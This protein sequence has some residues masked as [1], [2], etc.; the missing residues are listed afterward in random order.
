MSFTPGALLARA[1]SH[2][3]ALLLLA[4]AVLL[5]WVAERYGTQHDWTAAGRHTLAPA[6][7]AVLERL[8]GPLRVTAYARESGELRALVRSL[9][10]RYQRVRPDI[11][12]EFV[13]PDAVPDQVREL[14]ISSEGELVLAYRE[15]TERVSRL[16]ESAFSSALQRLLRGQ[17][18]WVAFLEGHGERDPDGR[19][20]HDLGEWAARLRERGLKVERLSL[21]GAG[22]VPDNTSLLV[23]AGPQV[24]LLPEESAAVLEYLERGGNLLWLLDPGPL[25][26]LEGLAGRLGLALAPGT[27]VDPGAQRLGIDQPTMVVVTQYPGH[28]ALAGFRYVSLFPLAG[29]LVGS[30]PEGWTAQ[31]LLETGASAWSESGELAGEV[32]YEEGADLPGPLTLGRALTRPAPGGAPGAEQR[33]AVVGD[34]DF[35]SNAYL[36]NGGNL[37][38]GTRLA[39]WLVADDTLVEI[40]LRSAPDARLELSRTQTLLMG[41]GFLLVLPAGLAG[42]GVLVWLRRRH[43]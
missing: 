17:Q 14:G 6:S 30:A 7:L 40:P 20:N 43:R 3:T 4:V 38:L 25:Q 22:A 21:A 32:S 2:A 33:V 9:V 42:A 35:L 39:E 19:A 37:E 31:P 29:A 13:N 36:G 34:G 23:I 11:A 12:L 28:A 26:G 16:E 1:G 27:V 41:F 15:R 10:A 24:A 5:V 8:E 18:R